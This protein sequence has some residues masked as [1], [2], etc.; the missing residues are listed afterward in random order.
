MVIQIPNFASLAPLVSVSSREPNRAKPP[1]EGR[2][3]F[4]S[5]GERAQIKY[6][7]PAWAKLHW[8][9]RRIVWPKPGIFI[10]RGSLWVTAPVRNPGKIHQHPAGGGPRRTADGRAPRRAADKRKP[11]QALRYSSIEGHKYNTARAYVMGDAY[12]L[13]IIASPGYL[14][15]KKIYLLVK[16]TQWLLVFRLVSASNMQFL[17]AR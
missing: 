1:D 7:Y 3:V 11:R 12:T 16:Q 9:V 14:P 17:V 4:V 2:F 6:R 8:L 5:E 15:T 10:R 13:G